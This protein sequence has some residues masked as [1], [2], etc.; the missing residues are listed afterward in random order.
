MEGFLKKKEREEIA[1]TMRISLQDTEYLPWNL[2]ELINKISLQKSFFYAIDAERKLTESEKENIKNWYEE[3]RKKVEEVIT[4]LSEREKE[5]GGTGKAPGVSE[6]LRANLQK[7][8][9]EIIFEAGRDASIKEP[10]DFLK[11][12]ELELTLI[13]HPNVREKIKKRIYDNVQ[14]ICNKKNIKCPGDFW[15]EGDN[16]T[17]TADPEGEK[18]ENEQDGQGENEPDDILPID[19]DAS[20]A[21]EQVFKKNRQKYPL[22]YKNAE[23]EF[24]GIM[25]GFMQDNRRKEG[26]TKLSNEGETRKK[27]VDD[28]LNEYKKIDKNNSDGEVENQINE[29]LDVIIK[30]C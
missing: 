29:F 2:E 12:L 14:D 13:T 26:I 6:K 8:L 3:I 16:E 21:A 28:L 5:R 11:I 30:E 18:T 17:N 10:R 1:K 19:F 15:D 22:L 27:V 4:D 25:K 20:Y 9:D 23:N 7:T 24:T